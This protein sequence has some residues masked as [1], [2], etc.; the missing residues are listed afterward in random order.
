MYLEWKSLVCQLWCT[1]DATCGVFDLEALWP[2]HCPSR[3]FRADDSQ[4]GFPQWEL[5]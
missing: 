3:L 1:L 4:T 2:A 5:A